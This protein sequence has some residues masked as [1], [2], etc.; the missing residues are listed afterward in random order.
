MCIFT[1]P[2]PGY[3]SLSLFSYPLVISGSVT[4]LLGF[5]GSVGALKEAKCMLA[6]VSLLTLFHRFKML[7]KVRILAD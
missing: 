6:I 3:L 7:Y 2:A 4:L 1:V 5:F